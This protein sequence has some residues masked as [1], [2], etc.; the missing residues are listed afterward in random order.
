MKKKEKGF[1]SR[2]SNWIF[3]IT[4]PFVIILL[5]QV[6]YSSGVFNKALL[7]SPKGTFITLTDLIFNGEIFLDFGFTFQRMFIGYFLA[8]LVGVSLGIFIGYFVKLYKVFEVPL[9][10]FRSLPV[11]AL[12]PLF[13]LIFGIG[14]S[15][16]IAMVFTASVFVIML[17]S[18]YGVLQSSKIR[19]EMAQLYDASS[20]QI[21]RYVT[22]YDSL[23]QTLI[24]LRIALSYSLIVEIVCEMFMGTQRGVG[25]RIFEAYNTY[26]IEELYGL[27]LLIGITGYLLNQF[28]IILEKRITHWIH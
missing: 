10:F 21:L 23:P 4:G 15:S 17:N 2:L 20:F 1:S 13:V 16:K 5:W 14:D 22:F 24:G 26:S 25:Q 6:S 12:Y 3:R 18:A 27:V 19:K 9:D 7:P 8:I 11:T 28:F